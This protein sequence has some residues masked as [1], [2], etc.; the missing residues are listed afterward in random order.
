MDYFIFNDPTTNDAFKRHFPPT[1][2][3]ATGKC[4]KCQ[5]E[6]RPVL[7]DGRLCWSRMNVESDPFT[8]TIEVIQRCRCGTST[9]QF[10]FGS[11][12]F[13]KA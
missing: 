5:G 3:W 13:T 12:G 2:E 7:L 11:E 1:L 9:G 6:L 4:F 10:I 8:I